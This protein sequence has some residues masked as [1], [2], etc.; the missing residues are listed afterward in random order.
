MFEKNE[1]KVGRGHVVKKSEHQPSNQTTERVT[2]DSEW[3]ELR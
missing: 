2:S 1:D 3:P